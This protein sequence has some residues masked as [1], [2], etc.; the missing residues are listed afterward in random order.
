L[1]E[2]RDVAPSVL[3][4]ISMLRRSLLFLSNQPSI[5]RLVRRNGF[6]KRFASRFV[7]GETLDTALDAVRAL[8]ARRIVP[9]KTALSQE[10]G[11]SRLR[12]CR[13]IMHSVD[14]LHSDVGR[15]TGVSAPALRPATAAQPLSRRNELDSRAG[16]RQWHRPAPP[17]KAGA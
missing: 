17:R 8:N 5:F 15:R 9:Q 11:G 16:E 10:I 4:P 14:P 12:R 13:A 2:V 3:L 6:A 7:A 1:N